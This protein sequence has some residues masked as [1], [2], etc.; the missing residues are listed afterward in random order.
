M[1]LSSARCGSTNFLMPSSIS[2]RSSA[3]MST[4]RSISATM[5]GDGIR[6]TSRA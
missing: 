2:T 6:S 5:L 3:T 4:S 1:S